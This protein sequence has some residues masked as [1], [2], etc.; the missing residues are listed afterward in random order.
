MINEII[1]FFNHPFFIIVGGIST[2]ALVLTALYSTYLVIKGV[3]PVWIR[4]GFGLSQRKIAIFADHGRYLELK[5][6][7][8]E[9]KIFQPKNIN[10][11]GKS[12]IKNAENVS[13]ILVHWEFAS[14]FIDQILEIKKA[15]DALIVYAPRDEKELPSTDLK[16]I[17]NQPNSILV[18]F[19]GRL[20]NDIL[21]SMITTS[22]KK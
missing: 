10:Q 2:V 1:S 4:L 21:V 13:L 11:Y 5:K 3:F 15:S 19:R 7:L 16:K 17:T 20:L 22:Y 6:M 9:S 14:E 8:E 12:T 18:N